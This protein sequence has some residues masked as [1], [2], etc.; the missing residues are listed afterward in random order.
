MRILGI[1]PGLRITG[2]GVIDYRPIRPLLIDGGVIRLT[3]KTPLADRLVEL[4]TELVSLL[5]EH[6][7][8]VCAVEQLYSHYAHPR[9][10][11]LMGHARGVILVAARKRGI[12]V[13]QFPANRVKQS[14]TGHGHASKSQM[15]RAIQSQWSLPEPPDPP[16]VADALAVALCCGLHLDRI[17]QMPAAGT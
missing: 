2:Y 17:R 4:E 7:P 11:I 14:V 5:E 9:T 3:P 13:E 15:Q 10:A 8:D 16:D 1:D 6:K 12:Q